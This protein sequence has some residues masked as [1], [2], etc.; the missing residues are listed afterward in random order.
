[1]RERFDKT[2]YW[3]GGDAGFRMRLD[4][5]ERFRFLP[6]FCM[7]REDVGEHGGDDAADDDGDDNVVEERHRVVADVQEYGGQTARSG[8]EAVGMRQAGVQSAARAA[9]HAG[10]KRI[11]LRQVHT[12]EQRFG[13]AHV[14]GDKAGCGDLFF[15]FVFGAPGDDQSRGRLSHVGADASGP[16][17]GVVA[18]VGHLHD[19]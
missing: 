6:L 10:D 8:G 2:S 3:R 13:D 18:E 16:K 1:M 5:F 11:F 19:A 12:V 9:D 4:G 7:E 15:L 14:R 17:D